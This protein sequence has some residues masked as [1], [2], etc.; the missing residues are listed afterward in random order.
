MQVS[1]EVYL[2]ENG[3]IQ[4]HSLERMSFDISMR[5]IDMRDE[6]MWKMYNSTEERA[7]HDQYYLE[8]ENISPNLVKE[9]GKLFFN[10][11]LLPKTLD[12]YPLT[13]IT[14]NGAKFIFVVYRVKKS[15]LR[16]YLP[17]KRLYEMSEEEKRGLNEKAASKNKV[18][19]PAWSSSE[20]ED[21][22]ES[23]TK[24]DYSVY[25]SMYQKKYNENDW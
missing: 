1:F 16:D 19:T 21:E 22:K 18:I 4:H 8:I 20:D 15:E 9:F 7:E 5:V 3:E 11:G 13:R 17:V 23:V 10:K 6:I 14:N 24:I 25:A 2:K 12:N